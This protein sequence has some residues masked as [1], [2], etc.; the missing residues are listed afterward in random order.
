[1]DTFFIVLF[2]F[3]V[4]LILFNKKKKQNRS[5][6][7]TIIDDT[8]FKSQ[9]N[10]EKA[11][12]KKDFTNIEP[13]FYKNLFNDTFINSLIHSFSRNIKTDY[14][15]CLYDINFINTLTNISPSDKKK[16]NDLL[17]I[18][19]SPFSLSSD[20][21]HDFCRKK[22]A[23]VF[24]E[25][26]LNNY[27][28]RITIT[29]LI[30]TY[31]N[32]VKRN[33]AMNE[34]NFFELNRGFLQFSIRIYI[35]ENYTPST[36]ILRNCDDLF[37]RISFTFFWDLI[38][39]YDIDNSLKLFKYIKEQFGDLKKFKNDYEIKQD[40]VGVNGEPI[41]YLGNCKLLVLVSFLNKAKRF[42]EAMNLLE[43][44]KTTFNNVKYFIGSDIDKKLI[45]RKAITNVRYTNLTRIE[46]AL[47]YGFID[48]VK[49]DELHSK[50]LKKM[51]IKPKF[52]TN[53][54]IPA[55]GISRKS[56]AFMHKFR[57]SVKEGNYLE[58][59]Q[60][61][62]YL[63]VYLD[64]LRLEININFKSAERKLNN[65]KK[66][67]PEYIKKYN[68]RFLYIYTEYYWSKR[69]V[70]Q[71]KIY[72]DKQTDLRTED[73]FDLYKTYPDNFTVQHFLAFQKYK[74]LLTNHIAKNIHQITPII[75]K[76]INDFYVLN[77]MTILKYFFDTIDNLLKTKDKLII[78]D[79]IEYNYLLIST[80]K[81]LI[82][83]QR[84]P[85]TSLDQ[86]MCSRISYSSEGEYSID[87]LR[88]RD[89]IN[90]LLT[91]FLNI[92]TREAENFFREKTDLPKIGEGW[93]AETQL[94]Y[95]I[96]DIFPKEKV[97]H[98]GH[99]SWLGKQHLDI[100]IPSI[101][102]GIEYQ[103][104]QHLRPVDY[105][106]GEDAFKE[107][108]IRDQRK[109]RLCEKNNC[110]LIYVYKNY[111]I[112]NIVEKIK[113]IHPNIFINYN[114]IQKEVSEKF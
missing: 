12:F 110:N 18:S 34:D 23:Y 4:G 44:I 107:T 100:F 1:M 93:I 64:K 45:S 37:Y 79:F 36:N 41:F 78:S 68:N 40:G 54:E 86:L 52:Y 65:L 70:K 25:L 55:Y 27:H 58:I 69:K 2:F 108:V 95:M 35:Y 66:L 29:Y 11:V 88:A 28:T 22:N 84:L 5:Q 109:K 33:S 91:K 85:C 3:L 75:E 50:I 7:S 20:L 48:K 42:E 16:A 104:E 101:N 94:F 17:Y 59:G 24:K 112:L 102:L 74:L 77:N 19:D 57:N 76:F 46:N 99:P 63:L 39:N 49:F 71:W 103:G 10:T 92:Y 80:E 98:H 26:G 6:T 60:E 62:T 38:Q 73:L 8:T 31:Q 106:G 9:S 61:T 83:L 14:S 114:N 82:K 47:K 105:F 56:N 53:S 13:A 111:K 51:N 96:S 113:K 97:I 90:S 87:Q 32:Y 89:I 72:F 15:S 30:E 67:Y 21:I 81:D 43:Y